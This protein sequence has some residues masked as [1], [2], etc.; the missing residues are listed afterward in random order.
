M[1]AW[2]LVASVVYAVQRILL[3]RYPEWSPVAR[4]LVALSPLIPTLLYLRS[5]VRFVR[6]MDE[7]Q[8]RVQLEAHVFAAWGAILLGVVLSVLHQ[9]GVL[10]VLPH[11]LGFGGAMVIL[12]SLWL[13]GI[14][15]AD[16]RYK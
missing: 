3:S 15:I 6:G 14:R 8:Q 11:G 9:H 12:F 10:D 16:R 7:L 1:N 13:V 4:A 5:W 2:L